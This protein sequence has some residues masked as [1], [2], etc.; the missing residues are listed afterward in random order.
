M[1]KAKTKQKKGLGKG[2]GL[3]AFFENVAEIEKVPASNDGKGVLTLKIRDVEPNPDQPRKEFDKEKLAALSDSIREHGVIQPV[4]VKQGKAGMYTIIAGER[5]WR[6][7][8][9]AGLTEIPCVIGEYSEKEIMEIAHRQ[10]FEEKSPL[11]NGKYQH[12]YNR[13]NEPWR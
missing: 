6:A 12:L 1:E 10:R 4:L 9:L 5:R 7:A 8:K 13:K 2:L 11:C 3:D